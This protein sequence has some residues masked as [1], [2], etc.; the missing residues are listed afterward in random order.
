MNLYFVREQGS[1][2]WGENGSSLWNQ[3][4]CGVTNKASQTYVGQ[5]I[6]R[7]DNV[8]SDGHGTRSIWK[9][10]KM[11]SDGLGVDHY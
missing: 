6:W 5:T 1:T 8:D 4:Q 3:H 10:I 7:Q 11:G 9:H 2:K